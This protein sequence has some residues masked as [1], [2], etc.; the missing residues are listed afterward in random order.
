MMPAMLPELG[1]L[2]LLS[3]M[4]WILLRGLGARRARNFAVL[5]LGGAGL[6]CGAWLSVLAMD[7]FDWVRR[8][9][10]SLTA[11]TAG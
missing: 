9:A 10:G 11:L 3:I 1:R 8:V 4:T 2:V 6:S 5:G 7:S